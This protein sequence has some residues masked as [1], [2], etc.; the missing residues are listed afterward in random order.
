[1]KWLYTSWPKYFVKNFDF[2]T[3]LHG[4]ITESSWELCNISKNNFKVVSQ[5]R[6]LLGLESLDYCLEDQWVLILVNLVNN[7]VFT[8]EMDRAAHQN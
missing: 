7:L 6:V 2:V 8:V 1:M 5:S 3:E 4:N